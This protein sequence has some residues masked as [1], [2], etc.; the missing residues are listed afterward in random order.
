MISEDLLA[1]PPPTLLPHDPAADELA[2][3]DDARDVVKRHPESPFA[4]ATL[5][6]L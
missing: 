1:G 2:A 6:E 5:A 4:W 3:G